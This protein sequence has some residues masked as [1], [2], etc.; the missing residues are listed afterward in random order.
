MPMLC[1]FTRPLQIIAAIVASTAEPFF[2]KIDLRKQR[3]RNRVLIGFKIMLKA[4]IF[5]LYIRI[6][7]MLKI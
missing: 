5:L 7:L 3:L 4:R 6:A 1:I 2:S